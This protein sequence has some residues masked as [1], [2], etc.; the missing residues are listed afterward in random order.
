MNGKSNFRFNH[1][2][3]A[4]TRNGEAWDLSELFMNYFFSFKTTLIFKIFGI[5]EIDSLEL[6]ATSCSGKT[7]GVSLVETQ[8]V[9]E[10]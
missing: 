7:L 5:F 6:F 1:P 2:P 8:K 9:T 4:V 10:K 3:T